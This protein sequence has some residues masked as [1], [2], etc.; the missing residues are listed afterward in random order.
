MVTKTTQAEGKVY[1]ENVIIDFLCTMNVME[2]MQ[3]WENPI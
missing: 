2:E 3:V 1:K